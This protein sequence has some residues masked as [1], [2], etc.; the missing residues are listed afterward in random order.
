MRL[1]NRINRWAS[2]T[3]VGLALAFGAE[4]QPGSVAVFLDG[5]EGAEGDVVV[6]L[7]RTADGFPSDRR[8]AY[9]EV[10]TP[11]TGTTATLVLEDVPSGAVAV[12][13]FHD[14]DR[15]GR[16]RLDLE[17]RPLDGVATAN[18]QGGAAPQFR[19]SALRVGE[20]VTVAR[21]RLWYP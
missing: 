13:A 11:A 20:G 2:A 19:R 9:R 15:D 7:Y 1:T 17:G 8:L 5:I 18:W 16:V 6:R 4:A 10:R 3:A 14:R 21:L 12:V